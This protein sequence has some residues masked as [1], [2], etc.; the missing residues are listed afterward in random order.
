VPE[1]V[2]DEPI[3][4]WTAAGR[5]DVR[6]VQGD[7]RILRE[8]GLVRAGTLERH[9]ADRERRGAGRGYKMTT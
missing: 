3:A 2:P 5:V 1:K 7:A 4:L 8:A 6:H 9:A